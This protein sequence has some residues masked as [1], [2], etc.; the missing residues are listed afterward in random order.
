VV[1]YADALRETFAG[2]DP[3][4]DD[5]LLLEAH[6]VVELLDRAPPADLA[7]LLHADPRLLRVLRLR[8]PG[9]RAR[10][11]AL[12]GAHG[13]VGAHDLPAAEQAVVWEVADLIAYQR[14]PA[15]YDERAAIPFAPSAVS[16]LAPLEQALV[17][18]AG[19]GTGRVAL[20]LAPFARL[21]VAVEP[22]A[23]L[24]RYLR[25]RCRQAGLSNVLVVDGTLDEM[26]L[27]AGCVD[28]LVTCHAVG[29]RLAA[30]VAEVERVLAPGGTAVHLFG[31]PPPPAVAAGLPAAGYR[32]DR[33]EAGPVVLWRLFRRR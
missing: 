6:E 15:L 26:P 3:V 7:A 32:A 14:A 1:T 12:L 18:D 8:C 24:R 23:A 17:V 30:E 16:T 25:D 4:A 33:Y 9:A 29:W 22:G 19:A 20:A 2:L 5:L 13:P 31:Q 28:V 11:E 27:P 10:L 21:V